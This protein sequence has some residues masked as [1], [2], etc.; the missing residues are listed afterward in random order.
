MSRKK[1]K[2]TA[3]FKEE[4]IKLVLEQN[5][6]QAEAARSLGISAK[7]L[8]RWIKERGIKGELGKNKVSAKAEQEELAQLHKEIKRLRIER[9][10]LKKAAAF[11]ANELN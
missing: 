7:N 2:P 1:S 4:A 3:E 8:S 9:E 11:F 5:Y 6:T 10:I